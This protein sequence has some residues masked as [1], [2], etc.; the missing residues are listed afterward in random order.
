MSSKLLCVFNPACDLEYSS[1]TAH[2]HHAA[3]R[4]T[5]IK[6][7]GFAFFFHLMTLLV[8]SRLSQHL[9]CPH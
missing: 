1:V 9:M 5:A 8:Y 4:G 2:M 7:V 3:T 6:S